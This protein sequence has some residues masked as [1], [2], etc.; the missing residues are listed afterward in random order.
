[1]ACHLAGGIC[2]HDYPMGKGGS[3]PV[4][5][6]SS[7]GGGSIYAAQGTYGMKNIGTYQGSMQ[8]SGLANPIGLA[9]Y[10]AN[11]KYNSA[12]RNTGTYVSKTASQKGHGLKNS[13]PIFDAYRSNDHERE[14]T[15]I[16]NEQ[17]VPELLRQPRD[18][19]RPSATIDD[20]VDEK[21]VVA[22]QRNFLEQMIKNA[23]QLTNAQRQPAYMVMYQ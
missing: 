2:P 6:S 14:K 15:Q 20:T 19:A 11:P 13:S 1:M 7:Y 16:E 21:N 23:R 17:A 18:T 5:G 12:Y 9:A 8:T 10:A 22:V 4:F 3:Y